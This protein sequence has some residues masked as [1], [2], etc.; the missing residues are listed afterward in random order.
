MIQEP[1]GKPRIAPDTLQLFPSPAEKQ[2]QEPSAAPKNTDEKDESLKPADHPHK[3]RT[4]GNK[5]YDWGI[6]TTF[7]WAGVAG[8]SLLSCHEANHGKNPNFDWLRSL[9]TNVSSG[10]HKFL[11]SGIMKG[12]PHKNIE[13]WA[14]GT[15]M[16]ATLGLGGCAMMVPI[17]WME[18]NRQKNAARIDNFL[19]TTPPD[20]KLVEQ[21][22]SQTWNSVLKGR[23]MSW[24]LSYL[25][26]A[27]MGP[28]TT[29]NI[30][31]WFGDKTTKIVMALRPQANQASVRK[32]ADIGAF[33]ATFT[34]ITATATYAFSRTIAKKHQ[35]HMHSDETLMTIDPAT[36]TP[37]NPVFNEKADEQQPEK[38]FTDTHKPAERVVSKKE[39][40][41]A[42]GAIK[43]K[44]L[45]SEGPALG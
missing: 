6:Y 12:A 33:D 24:G 42:K 44:D 23:L 7:A 15:A 16:F 8:L 32:W 45:V 37:L 41:Y 38:R 4:V 13:G 28:K 35:H 10:L 29:N 14:K 34:V 19:G 26:F 36:P 17:K 18:D 31:N 3:H 20:P 39:A 30:S 27:A 9:N 22:I 2:K 21:E 11:E 1:V 25:A 40:T 5:I 43:S